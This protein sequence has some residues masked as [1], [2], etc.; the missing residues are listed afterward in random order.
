MKSKLL[1]YWEHVD[2]DQA[3]FESFI[4][5]K[6]KEYTTLFKKTHRNKDASLPCYSVKH[7]EEN[8]FSLEAGYFVG[9]DWID[10][11]VPLF[12]APK[13]NKEG[14][15]INFLKMLFSAL[16]HHEISKEISELFEVKWEDE[17]IEIEQR[18]DLLTPFLVVEFLSVLKLIVRKGL[19]KS[20]YKVEKNLNARVKGKVQVSKTIKHNHSKNKHL[21]TFCSF[22]EFGLNSKENRLLKKTLNFVKRYLKYYDGLLNNV[23]LQNTYN[24]I[25]PA[26]LSVSDDIDLHE[27]KHTKVNVFYKEYEQAVHLARLILKRFGY[28]I[29]NISKEVITTPPFWIDMSKLFELYVLGL[30]KDRFGKNVIYQFR[31]YGNELDYLL[32]DDHFKMVIDAK[33][34]LKYLNG[35]DNDDIRQISGYAR[36]KKVYETLGKKQ[37]EVIDCLII[38]PDQTNGEVTFDQTNF[39]G[40]SI[41]DFFDIY[42][43]GVF[44]PM[45]S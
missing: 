25:S 10:K 28:N 38:H 40:T 18:Q 20:Y 8:S 23:D 26:F 9:V 5:D 44:L 45:I 37:G 31:R 11:D 29:T 7:L 35:K 36:L 17:Q 30:L 14:E 15:E 3:V 21:Y 43:T 27:I 6:R 13:L 22:D 33:Y 41:P 34:K 12:I 2:G 16:R 4:L 1:S 19:K 24:F 32:N 42:K 39:K